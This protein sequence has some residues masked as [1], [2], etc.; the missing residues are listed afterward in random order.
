MATLQEMLLA[1]DVQ[2]RVVADCEELVTSQVADMSGVT[3]AAVKL[4]YNTVRRVDADHIHAMIETI[5]PNVA[6]ALQPYWAQFTAEFTPSSGDFGGYLAAREEEV[7]EALLAITD[8]R[9]DNSN[10]PA[11]VKAYNTIRGRAI[12]QVK[13]AL[14][15]LGILIQKYA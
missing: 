6:D 9:R 4:A 2:P 14:P 11:I 7:A 15:A 8:R 3:G 5:L 10:R 1:S 13:A 12:K